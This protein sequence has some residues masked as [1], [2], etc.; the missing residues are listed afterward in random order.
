MF[1]YV[2]IPLKQWCVDFHFKYLSQD[3]DHN[4]YDNIR[5]KETIHNFFKY[6]CTV[7]AFHWGEG[8]VKFNN[9]SS[10]SF[11]HFWWKYINTVVT[12]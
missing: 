5:D 12:F 7:I 3:Y 2:F 11:A 6:Y 10:N 4:S 1:F 9:V 8:G